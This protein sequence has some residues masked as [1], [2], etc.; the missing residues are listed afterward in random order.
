VKR[1]AFVLP[2]YLPANLPGSGIFVVALAERLAEDGNDVTVITSDAMDSRSWYAPVFGKVIVIKR[3]DIHGV[4]VVR[5]STNWIRSSIYYVLYRLAKSLLPRKFEERI[6]LL[7]SGPIFIGLTEQLEVGRFDAVHCS[8]FPLGINYQLLMVLNKI[9]YKPRFIIAPFFHSKIGGYTNPMLVKVA[10]YADAIHVISNSEATDV[11]R[12]LHVDKKSIIR[13]PLSINMDL[14]AE[15]KN[16]EKRKRELIETYRLQNRIVILFAGNKGRMKGAIDLLRVMTKLYIEDPRYL[17]VAIGNPMR[18]WTKEIQRV[19]LDCVLDLP[20]Q[21]GVDKEAWF[22]VARVYTMPSLS[23]SFG[24]VYLEAWHKKKP[25]IGADIPAVSELI[26]KNK[27][28]LL[29]PFEDS[30]KLAEAIRRLSLDDK[31]AW[32][33]GYNGRKALIKK[34]LFDQNYIQYKKLFS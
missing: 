22:S 31:L 21:L 15:P 24:L 17:F 9:T 13:I 25:V 20:Y 14:F 30:N 16:V 18:E 33:L 23:E 1:I 6:G 19:N 10:K 5:L 12:L 32:R 27:G 29:V 8:P 26:E 28:G 11:K 34:Y 2:Q 7:S 4:H 3:E